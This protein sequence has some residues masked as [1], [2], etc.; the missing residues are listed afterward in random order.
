M[1]PIPILQ[2]GIVKLMKIQGKAFESMIEECSKYQDIGPA[3]A[4]KP[5]MKTGL[6]Q[7]ILHEL[8]CVWME[9]PLPQ[10]WIPI[11]DA[12]TLTSQV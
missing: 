6:S 8:S 7:P 11:T 10:K 2:D 4:I 5:F 1:W 3:Q 12:I 9:L